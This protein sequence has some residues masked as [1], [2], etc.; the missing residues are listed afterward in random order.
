MAIVAAAGPELIRFTLTLLGGLAA[1]GIVVV[2]GSILTFYLLRDGAAGSSS[3]T[4]RFTSWRHDELEEVA[5]RAEPGARRLHDRH[6]RRVGG[7]GRVRSSS[8]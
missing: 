7:R 8:S 4:S 1:F 2:V 6:G 5:R 3:S